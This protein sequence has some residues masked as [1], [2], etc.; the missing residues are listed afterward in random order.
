MN[1]LK[2][3]IHDEL[4]MHRVRNVE[5]A[6]QLV[7]KSKEKKIK[8]LFRGIEEQGG[9]HCL[10]CRVVLIMTEVN[11]LKELRKL[12]IVN[13]I[14]QIHHEEV[15]F[16]EVEVTMANEELL[17]VLSAVKRIIEHLNAQIITCKSQSKE[18]NLH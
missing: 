1:Y 10:L 14:I 7:L 12:K 18:S 3:S 6:Y 13:K 9:V 5:D 16:I 4:S 11:L 15:D 17:F 2:F 8:N